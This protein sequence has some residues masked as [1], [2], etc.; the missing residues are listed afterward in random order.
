MDFEEVSEFAQMIYPH[1]VGKHDDQ[2]SDKDLMSWRAF[3]YAA[4]FLQIR[5]I[6]RDQKDPTAKKF[7]DVYGVKISTKE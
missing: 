4:T 1:I 7:R 2:K 6:I 3:G 5:E